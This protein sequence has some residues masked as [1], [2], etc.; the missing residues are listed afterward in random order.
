MVL[1]RQ[2]SQRG[3]GVGSRN[4]L[5]PVLKPTGFWGFQGWNFQKGVGLRNLLPPVSQTYPLLRFSRLKASK[6]GRFEKSLCLQTTTFP[7]HFLQTG[8]LSFEFG[9]RCLTDRGLVLAS[10]YRVRIPL[11]PNFS[12]LPVFEVFRAETF[13]KGW[14]WEIRVLPP[15]SQTYPLLRFSRLKAS[16]RGRFEK[17]LCLQTTTFPGHF[18]QTGGLSFEFGPRCLTDRGLVLASGYRVRIPLKPNFSNLPVFEVFRAE[19]FKKGW[20]WEIFSHQFLKPRHFLQTGGLSFEFGPRCL[21]DRALVL[22]SGYRVR[23]PLKPNFSNLPVFEVFR[24]ETFKKG[25]VWEIFS[26]Q[27]LKPTLFWGFQGWQHQKGV[28][29]RNLLPPVFS[30]R[31]RL[32]SQKGLVWEIFFSQFLQYVTPYVHLTITDL[33][34]KDPDVSQ[35]F[36][37]SAT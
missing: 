24:A 34:H 2:T 11:K 17:S 28:V 20:V 13:K 29:L 8:G 1:S 33:R 19:T 31:R 15:V 16:K 36:P 10:G 25:W 32:N 21:T 5:P 4:L 22:A 7:G 3:K 23:I 30:K 27:F 14:V 9:P 35:Y 18:L 12:N 26:H 37:I 6:R